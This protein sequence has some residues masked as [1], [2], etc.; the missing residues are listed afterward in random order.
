MTAR[1]TAVRAH[2]RWWVLAALLASLVATPSVVA[3]LP[4][5]AA[6]VPPAQLLQRIRASDQVGWSGYGES[7]GSLVLPDAK[8]L[9][10]LPSLLAGTT[11]VR[12]WW[13]GPHDSRLDVLA[14][15]TET[16]SGTDAQGTWTYRPADY[17]AVR[18][19]GTVPVHLPNAGDLLAPVLGRRLAATAA[20][21]AT[22]LPARRVAGRA[23]AG[24]R[25]TPTDPAATT[26]GHVDLWA[27]AGSGL[28]LRVDV[29]A[30]GQSASS[31]TSVLVDL[32]LR[33]PEAART[34]FDV[35]G[36]TYV[37]VQQAPDVVAALERA[38]RYVL[39]SSLL[40]L[41]RTNPLGQSGGGGVGTYGTGFG[42]LAV[43]PVP[44][45]Q[46]R[47][48]VDKLRSQ[49]GRIDTPLVSGLLVDAGRRAYVLSGLVPPELLRRIGDEL[50]RHPPPRSDAA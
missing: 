46:A 24:L 32:S 47:T 7:R 45:G 29:V 36:T 33:R 41:P 27:D 34:R 37:D 23:A 11:R 40:G 5:H 10:D 1:R 42:V 17:Q 49:G 31:L 43:V 15:A 16:D 19:F 48:L 20:T 3:A 8:Q 25:L 13:R 28:P 4:V 38:L 2:W 39:P 50:V 35:P 6:Q 14:L 9:G 18:I 22:S 44:P 21:R 30:R 26:V 12:A